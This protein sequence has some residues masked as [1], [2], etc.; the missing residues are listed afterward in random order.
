M[1]YIKRVYRPELDRAI[2]C[3]P[4]KMTEGELNYFI[5]RM[6]LTTEPKTYADYNTLVGVLECIKLEFYRRAIVPY[7]DRKVIENGDVY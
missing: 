6:L 2:E 3:L 7:E 4:E 5:T 1:P